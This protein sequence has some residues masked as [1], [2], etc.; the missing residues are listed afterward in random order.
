APHLRVD[1]ADGLVHGADFSTDTHGLAFEPH[2]VRTA[3]L[4]GLTRI[5]QPPQRHTGNAMTHEPLRR[6]Y[7]HLLVLDMVEVLL[8]LPA[9]AGE[10]FHGVVDR[11]GGFGHQPIQAGQRLSSLCQHLA[12]RVV[13]RS[14]FKHC[15]TRRRCG[16]KRDCARNDPLTGRREVK[17]H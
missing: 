16:V 7:D 9:N 6:A 1:D 13:K 15:G 2:Q 8:H 3:A 17:A 14:E 5:P 10:Q 12:A 4:A 11:L